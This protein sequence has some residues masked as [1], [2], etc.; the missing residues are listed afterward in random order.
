MRTEFQSVFFPRKSKM[1]Q[2]WD[3]GS[4]YQVTALKTTY[5]PNWNI[6]S[7]PYEND[8]IYCRGKTKAKWQSTKRRSIFLQ[9]CFTHIN[10]ISHSSKIILHLDTHAD[11]IPFC[12][13]KI[14]YLQCALLLYYIGVP[15]YSLLA[16]I[17]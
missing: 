12:D 15:A 8:N 10:N 13:I 16:I 2:Q 9:L 17:P 7:E 11:F 5:L 14:M 4:A 3:Q 6:R 1:L